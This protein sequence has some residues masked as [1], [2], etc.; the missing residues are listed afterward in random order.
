MMRLKSCIFFLCLFVIN[1]CYG[2]NHNH[3]GNGHHGDGDHHGGHGGGHHGGGHHD[4]N[5]GDNRVKDERRGIVEVLQN[6]FLTYCCV[7]ECP[8]GFFYAGEIPEVETR[9]E[10]WN[11]GE[12]SPVYS[13]YSI[14]RQNLNWVSANQ[15]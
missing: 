15:E 12:T 8:E 6:F 7:L 10:V 1:G 4:G 2:H 9:G 3:D 13:C 11:K 5:H 14:L